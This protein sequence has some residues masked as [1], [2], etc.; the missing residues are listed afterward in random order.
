MK[1]VARLVVLAYDCNVLAVGA[2]HKDNGGWVIAYSVTADSMFWVRS[3]Q[4]DGYFGGTV[5][6]GR[7]GH[8]RIGNKAV[9]AG[10]VHMYPNTKKP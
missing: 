10:F 8:H 3:G 9:A 7:Y 2:I 6:L 5:A 4:A 1:Y